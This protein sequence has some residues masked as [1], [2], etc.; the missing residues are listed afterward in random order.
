MAKYE[1]TNPLSKL[2]DGEPYF[3]LRAQDKC[4]PK[5][6]N[7]YAKKLRD[8]GDLKGAEECHAFARRMR[9]WQIDN[10]DKV[11]MPD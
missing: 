3:F 8:E 2:H 11:K 1:N 5:A 4:A 9:Q 7:E 6:V 10:P